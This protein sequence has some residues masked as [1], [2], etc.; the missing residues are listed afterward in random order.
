MKRYIASDFHISNT[1]ADIDRVMGFLNLVDDDADEFLIMGDWLDLLWSN[2]T[3]ISTVKPYSDIFL[4]FR[5]IAASKPVN[6][7]PGNHDWNLSMFASL[8]DPVKIVPAFA[9]N[10]VYFT[11]GHQWDWVALITGTPVDPIY[12]KQPFPFLFPPAF[13][14]WAAA[15]VWASAAD[16]YSMA[17]AVVQERA[18][19]YAAENG[20]HTVV[21]GHTHY[22]T[23]DSLGGIKVINDG[24]WLD[25][26]SYVL[27]NDNNFE[28]KVF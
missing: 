15:K 24:D 2:M 7:I 14:T 13:F 11:H 28:V 12:L 18:R 5:Q 22:P 1:I 23:Y 17:V 16:T 21:L 9:E 27:Q 20:Y 25:S 8:I 4:K 26:Y 6:C 19:A 10:G 3:I